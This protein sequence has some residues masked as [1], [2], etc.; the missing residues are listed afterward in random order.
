MKRK[1]SFASDWPGPGREETAAL[2]C[3][4]L[5]LHRVSLVFSITYYYGFHLLDVFWGSHSESQLSLSGD[6][7]GCWLAELTSLRFTWRFQDTK[8]GPHHRPCKQSPWG[9]CFEPLREQSHSPCV[10]G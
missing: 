8:P 3:A 4:F 10:E 9:P 7:G 2:E 1:A 6:E 5:K